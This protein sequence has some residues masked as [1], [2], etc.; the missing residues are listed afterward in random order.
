MIHKNKQ[1]IPITVLAVG[2]ILFAHIKCNFPTRSGYDQQFKIVHKLLIKLKDN[3]TAGVR[4]M[5][6]ANLSDIGESEN[7][8]YS[9]I[10]QTSQLLKRFKMPDE[11][12]YRLIRYQNTDYRLLDMMIPLGVDTLEVNFVK[13]LPADKI[14]DFSLNKRIKADGVIAPPDTVNALKK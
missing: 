7:G 4:A 11:E 6:G 10:G 3:D 13:Y 8:L 5:F 9:K 12:S 2:A 14:I 1:Y